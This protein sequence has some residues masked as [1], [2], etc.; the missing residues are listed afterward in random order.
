M[1]GKNFDL[2]V[3]VALTR[4]LSWRCAGLVRKK[5]SPATKLIYYGPCQTPALSFCIYRAN[6][7]KAFQKRPFF[8]VATSVKAAL[9]NRSALT[10]Y[11]PLLRKTTSGII[12]QS[13][14]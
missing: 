14:V 1:R 3:G 2:R 11:D 12:L 6:E 10:G 4:L 9:E 5:F 13:T 7:V 8:Q